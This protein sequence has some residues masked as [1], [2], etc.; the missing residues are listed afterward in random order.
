[1]FLGQQ[2][3]Q[4]PAPGDPIFSGGEPPRSKITW[5]LLSMTTVLGSDRRTAKQPNVADELPERS[6]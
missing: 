5:L 4:S 2:Q 3:R 1:M 6:F